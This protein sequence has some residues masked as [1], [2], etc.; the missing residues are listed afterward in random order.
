MYVLINDIRPLTDFIDLVYDS[1]KNIK[2][3]FDDNGLR[4]N[5]LND[6]HITFYGAEYSKS[7]FDD[8]QVTDP[9]ELLFDSKDIQ[10]ILKSSK[11]NEDL[12]MEWDNESTVKFIFESDTNRRVFEVGLIDELYD[13]PVPPS[14]DYDYSFL[15]EWENLKQCCNDLGISGTD[16]FIISLNNDGIF[17]N[18]PS[19][20]MTQYNNRVSEESFDKSVRSIVNTNYIGGLD[21]LKKHGDLILSVGD[22]IPVS[23][24]IEDRLGEFKY[25]GL[26]APIFEEDD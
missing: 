22:N 2:L 16:R 15:M 7:F 20:S 26:I 11:N 18:S 24:S 14:I 12:M 19:S 13:A 17:V 10:Q 8:Y 9:I 21:K 25:S 1:T 4:I 6:G 5:L 23:W 3:I